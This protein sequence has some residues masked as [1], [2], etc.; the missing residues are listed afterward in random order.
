MR[1]LWSFVP[2]LGCWYPA[3]GLVLE[4]RA[5]GHRVVGLS[6]PS[7]APALAALGIEART[8]EGPPWPSDS[9]L[10][11]GPPVDL[12]QAL[13]RKVHVARAHRDH[14]ARLLRDERFDLVLADGFRL[15]AGFAADEAG[16][17][18]A[19]YTHHQFADRATSEGLVQ[20][21]WDRFRP[22]VSLRK[23]FIDWWPTLRGGLGAGPEPL[24][25]AQATWWNQ[26]PHATLVLG[27][28][29]LLGHRAPAPAWVHHVGPSLWDGL[30]TAPPEWLAQL[31]RDRPAVLVSLGGHLRGRRHPRRRRG[32][33]SRPRHAARRDAVH[34]P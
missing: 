34:R 4:L 3:V 27:L 25:E 20:M 8:D 29:E 11:S 12:D 16:V 23:T 13:R 14:V 30:P 1:V 18:W 10:G 17:P 32:G 9:G 5:R 15:G 19:S 2:Q 6:G 7:V 26:S 21:W 33:G 24:P 22:D 28:P 31:G